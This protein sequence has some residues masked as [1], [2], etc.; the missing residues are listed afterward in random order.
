MSN[1]HNFSVSNQHG[2]GEQLKKIFR[3]QLTGAN[4]CAAANL[5]AN[6]PASFIKQPTLKT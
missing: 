1:L 3:R 4:K 2:G 5:S 6:L